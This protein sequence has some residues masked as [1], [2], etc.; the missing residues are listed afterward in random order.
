M[1][2]GVW[3]EA[4]RSERGRGQGLYKLQIVI[5]IGLVRTPS[6]HTTATA[7]HIRKKRKVKIDPSEG[8]VYL[9]GNRQIAVRDGNNGMWTV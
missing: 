1:E 4:T 2:F 3:S 9:L 6:R 8:S 7:R 5:Y